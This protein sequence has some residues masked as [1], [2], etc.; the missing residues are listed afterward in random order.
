[1]L[2]IQLLG[3]FQ[4]TQ[5][6]QILTGFESNKVRALLAMLVDQPGKLHNREQLASMLWPDKLRPP[7][8]RA[9]FNLRQTLPDPEILTARG[10]E[11]ALNPDKVKVDCAVLEQTILAARSHHHHRI[12]TCDACLSRLA[13]MS[14]FAAEFLEDFYVRDSLPFEDWLAERR[15]HYRQRMLWTL[16][17]LAAGHELK[18][19]LEKA[20]EFVQ[21]MREIDPWNEKILFRLIRLLFFNGQTPE[22]HALYRQ[23]RSEW[24]EASQEIEKWFEIPRPGPFSKLHNLPCQSDVSGDCPQV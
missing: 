10:G 5:E 6:N 14:T 18:M 8:R 20:I 17:V 21:Q 13:I 7:F 23:I 4:A 22:A 3:K 19:Q 15:H 16:D 9:L 24:G 12:E 1:M 2:E 11:I